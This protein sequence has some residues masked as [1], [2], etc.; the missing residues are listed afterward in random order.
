[1]DFRWVL[2]GV[3]L[4]LILSL[5]YVGYRRTSGLADFYVARRSLSTLAAA[6]TF[7][8]TFTSAITFVG[9]IGFGWKFGASIFPIYLLPSLV[10]FCLMALV[11]GKINRLGHQRNIYTISDFYGGRYESRGLQGLTSLLI[12]FAYIFY[13]VIQLV[14]TGVVF[15]VLLGVPYTTG[16]LLLGCVYTLYTLLGGMKSVYITDMLQAT[17]F[18]IGG[19]LTF[20]FVL[21]KVGGLGGMA[22]S[23]AASSA[24]HLSLTAGGAFKPIYIIGLVVNVSLVCLVHPMYLSRMMASKNAHAARG[25]FGIG[26]L[27]LT[28][29]YIAVAFVALGAAVLVK[30]LANMDQAFPTLVMTQIPTAVGAFI[31]TCLAAAV[32]STTDSIL[33]IVGTMTANDLYSKFVNPKASEKTLMGVARYAILAFSAISIYMAIARPAYIY[34]IY[35]FFIVLA[36][37]PFVAIMVLGLYWKRATKAGAWM[38]C[39]T[40]AVSGVVLQA[41]KI[42]FSPVLVAVPLSIVVMVIVSYLTRPCSETTI[43]N[44]VEV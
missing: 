18:I 43:K 13:L 17:L 5:G 2:F 30:D 24:S 40:G 15:E 11:A 23:L 41:I 10:G 16:V 33:L 6:G 38:G 12:L 37:A 19:F 39:L 8:G 44:W 3:Y 34:L 22:S 27:A 1:M 20:F 9:W 42:P 36:T 25:M 28:L 21:S 35:N 29:F 32:M 31:L 7:A 26:G 14:G 4:I